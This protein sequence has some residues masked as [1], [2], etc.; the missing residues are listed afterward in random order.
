MSERVP[1]RSSC[2]GPHQGRPQLLGCEVA[3]VRVVGAFPTGAEPQSVITAIEIA[4]AH[5]AK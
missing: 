2:R 5:L 3:D 4:V 1:W